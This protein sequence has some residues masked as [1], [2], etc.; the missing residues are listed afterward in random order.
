MELDVGLIPHQ[1]LLCSPFNSSLPY[2]LFDILNKL[3][4]FKYGSYF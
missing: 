1:Q 2:F 4:L 3:M